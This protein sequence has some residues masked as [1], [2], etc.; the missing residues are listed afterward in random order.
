MN[1]CLITGSSSG[2]GQAITMQCLAEG[3]RVVGLARRADQIQH[4]NYHAW[5]IDFS[6]NKILNTQ[7][8]ELVQ[9]HPDI[10]HI[11]IAAGYGQ[12]AG[13]ESFSQAQIEQ[14]MQV[15]FTAQV[16]L[17]KKYLPYFKQGGDH[18]IIVIGSESSL[19]GGRQGG[20]YSASKFA[21]RGFCQSLREEVA[22]YHIPVTM[23]HPGFC[24][25]PFFDN[26]HFTPGPA[27]E[28]A[29]APKVVSQ[30]VEYLLGLDNTCVV[31]E[32]VLQPMLKQAPQKC[33]N[34]T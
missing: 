18:K 11:I 14:L 23:I 21:L 28:H 10:N 29:I 8:Q 20:L 17:I 15:N 24:R 9:A 30:T 7:Y 13:V 6:D 33:G 12:F 22:K 16:L 34:K 5:C 27:A 2:L 32:I 1:K 25:T 31:E 3:Y 26:L 19:Q 4:K